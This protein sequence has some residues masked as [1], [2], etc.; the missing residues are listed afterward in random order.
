[1]RLLAVVS[2]DSGLIGEVGKIEKLAP[3][4]RVRGRKGHKHRVLAEVYDNTVKR[5]S[6]VHAAHFGAERVWSMPHPSLASEDFTAYGR[7]GPH[8]YPAPTIPTVFW[9]LGCTDPAIWESGPAVDP[10]ERLRYLPANHS[11][12]FSIDVD[13][14]L[15]TGIEAF[16]HGSLDDA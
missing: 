4:Q 10:W 14:T 3:R 15:R 2:L 11:S 13:L 16:C 1:M 8:S 6:D 9:F 7:P 5:I 12:R